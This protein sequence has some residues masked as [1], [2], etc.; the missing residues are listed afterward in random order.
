[1]YSFHNIHLRLFARG[2]GGGF[3]GGGPGRGPGSGPG[4]GPGGEGLS[5]EMRETAMAERGGFQRVNLGLPGP[6]LDAII[7]F[8][9]GK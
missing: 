7:E 4:S 6:M 1:M 9:E 2:P 8:L 5:P 3:P